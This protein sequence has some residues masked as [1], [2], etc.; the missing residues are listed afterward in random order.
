MSA[1]EVFQ[2]SGA[3][4]GIA[5]LLWM[6]LTQ[7]WGSYES[8]TLRISVGGLTENLNK[9]TDLLDKMIDLLETLI[10]TQRRRRR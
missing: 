9:T 4:A 5:S 2:I 1:G 10:R 7:I 8:Q 6:M 3:T